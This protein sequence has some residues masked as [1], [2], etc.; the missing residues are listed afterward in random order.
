MIRASRI[1]YR[2]QPRNREALELANGTR[3]GLQPGVFT[4]NVKTALRAAQVLEFGGVTVNEAPT[5]RADPDAI[6]RRQ[7]LGNTRERPAYAV[8]TLTEERVVVLQ[9]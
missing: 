1:G 6:R 2:V 8:R 7:G 3:Y 5:L 9:L 4:A